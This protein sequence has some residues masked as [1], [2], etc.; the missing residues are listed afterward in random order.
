MGTAYRTTHAC[1]HAHAQ[2]HESSL[3]AHARTHTYTHSHAHAPTHTYTT[4][5]EQIWG[6]W[7]K[8]KLSIR[9]RDSGEGTEER[10]EREPGGGGGFGTLERRALGRLWEF[11]IIKR[12]H[13][14]KQ[15]DKKPRMMTVG[16]DR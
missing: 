15:N 8:T 5:C 10:R 14:A 11:A 13:L 6:P 3:D 4:R 16:G 12:R 2:A 1:T 9:V 7:G